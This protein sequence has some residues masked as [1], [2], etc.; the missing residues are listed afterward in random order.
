[1]AMISK[2]I[3]RYKS[4][5]H[6]ELI[7]PGACYLQ[8]CKLECLEHSLNLFSCYSSILHTWKEIS[9]FYLKVPKVC[10]KLHN[11]GFMSEL[12]H[13]IKFSFQH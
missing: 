2:K 7:A 5:V 11:K 13:C 8:A 12:S 4:M 3:V 9:E 1:M 6:H 10:T